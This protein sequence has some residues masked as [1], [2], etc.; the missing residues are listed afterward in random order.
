MPCNEAI[1]LKI[2]VLH[3]LI[4]KTSS[5]FS[6]LL[7]M[8]QHPS[9]PLPSIPFFLEVRCISLF[10]LLPRFYYTSLY[11]CKV[12]LAHNTING[13]MRSAILVRCTRSFLILSLEGALYCVG[14]W[15]EGYGVWLDM[16][17]G[18]SIMK[19]R[20]SG[21]AGTIKN[22]WLKSDMWSD[23]VGAIQLSFSAAIYISSLARFDY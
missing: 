11:E 8:L 2:K 22:A 5:W 3:I 7:R 17:D 18:L 13:M 19:L 4:T 9:Y 21:L 15:L 20:M 1:L 14:R 10:V 12:T 16:F 6:I 23:I